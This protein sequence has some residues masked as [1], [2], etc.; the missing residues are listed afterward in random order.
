MQTLV[1]HHG[2]SFPYLRLS[3]TEACNYRCAYC[4][5]DGYQANGRPVFLVLEEIRRLVRGF[6]ALGMSKIR[7]TGGEPSLRK[8]LPAIIAAVAAVPGIRRIA[9]TTN[10]CRLPRLVRGWREAGLTALNVSLDSLD[11]ARYLDITGHDRFAEV[12]E[13]IEQAL[14][15][16]FEA[17]KINAVLLRGR[18]DDELPAWLDYLRG[19]DVALR[20]IELMQTGENREFFERHHLRA[21]GLQ[22]QLLADGWVLRPR[23]ADAGPALEY[24]H[25]DYRGR[26]GVIAPYARDF[27]AGCNRLRVTA[28]GDLRLCLFGN[29]GVSLRPLLQSDDDHDAL[30][31]HIATQLGL[32]A[33]GHGLHQGLTGITPHLASIGG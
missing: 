31:A 26:I 12:T 30:V 25:P 9:L 15:L 6:A 8:D 21:E 32:K 4:L 14:A 13:G 28:R 18:N 5:P 27:C 10:G 23:A 24:A 7:L 1:D 19:R 33:A 29:F 22:R 3:L 11:A 16:G 20:F 17:V 2:R